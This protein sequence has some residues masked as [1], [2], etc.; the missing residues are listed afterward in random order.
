MKNKKKTLFGAKWDKPWEDK[1]EQS[2]YASL[3]PIITPFFRSQLL[4]TNYFSSLIIY[5][6]YLL[7]DVINIC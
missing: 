6:I 5:F 1:S 3:F 2:N 4:S 7:K